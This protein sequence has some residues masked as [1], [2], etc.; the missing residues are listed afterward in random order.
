MQADPTAHKRCC[1]CEQ[2]KSSEAFSADRSA[3]DGLASRCRECLSTYRRE[4]RAKNP[5]HHRAQRRAY[6]QRDPSK[7][8][9]R[10]NE[11]QREWRA[12][13][14]E[15]HRASVK[16]WRDANPDEAKRQAK[17]KQDRRRAAGEPSSGPRREA[18]RLLILERDDGVC[19][20]CGQDVDPFDFTLDHIVPIAR[21]GAHVMSNLQLAHAL[22]NSHKYTSLEVAA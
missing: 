12:A 19:G 22:C 11:R 1:A 17:E 16:A 3:P 7:E 18:E 4:R 2:D 5:E 15:A 20:I 13:N 8:R 9:A 14:P 21:G 10:G 6:Y